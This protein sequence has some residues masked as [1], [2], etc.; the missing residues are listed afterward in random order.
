M[1]ISPSLSVITLTALLTAA[2]TVAQPQP[3]TSASSTTEATDPDQSRTDTTGTTSG[4]PSTTTG[5]TTP[6][7]PGTPSSTEA[8]AT[9]GSDAAA[10]TSDTTGS[11]SGMAGS[12]T[13]AA[14]A[15]TMG[16][17]GSLQSQDAEFLRKALASGM[18]E[19]QSA[20]LAMQQAQRSDTRSAASMMLQDHQRS[21]QE[22]QSLAQR[23][24]W[25]VDSSPAS[26]Q[27]DEARTRLTS[28]SGDF[29]SRYVSEEIRHHR[30]AIA[31]FRKEASAGSDPD[32]R[33]FAT[34]TLPKLEHHLDMLESANTSK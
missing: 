19:V 3:A 32:L 9:S 1:R 25:P 15:A 2:A 14:T 33:Q 26:A 31:D 4:T 23:K 20:Q 6:T 8:T 11:T 10:G 12:G 13:S 18:E 34:D 16:G 21:N 27:S 7:A 24:G 22:L 29:D 17:S 28:G 30:E 5:T